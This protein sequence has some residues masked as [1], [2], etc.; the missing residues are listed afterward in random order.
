M[1]ELLNAFD[2]PVWKTF[3][4]KSNFIFLCFSISQSFFCLGTFGNQTGFGVVGE[5]QDCPT[6]RYCQGEGLLSSTDDCSPGYFCMGKASQPSPNDN[7]TGII[8][9]KG[10]F[11]SK[12]LSKIIKTAE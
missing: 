7:V 8:C 4:F 2:D 5:C 9:P 11:L 6:G 3:S 1:K 10:K 12:D